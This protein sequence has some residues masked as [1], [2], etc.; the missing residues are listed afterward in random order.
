MFNN[1]K[2]IDLIEQLNQKILC[3]SANKNNL[4][5][6]IDELGKRLELEHQQN[7]D[8]IKILTDL[9]NLNLAG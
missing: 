1:G 3:L 5:H 6:K 4:I 7:T 9:I 8:K 2:P